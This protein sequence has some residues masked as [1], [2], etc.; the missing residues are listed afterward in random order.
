MD[1]NMRPYKHYSRL[2]PKLLA[3]ARLPVTVFRRPVFS[4]DNNWRVSERIFMVMRIGAATLSC[5]GASHELCL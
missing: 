1:L 4:D 2:T 5:R 3:G